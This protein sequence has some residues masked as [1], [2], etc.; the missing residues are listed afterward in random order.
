[1]VQNG[2]HNVNAAPCGVGQL[3]DGC[4]DGVDVLRNFGDFMLLCKV[5]DHLQVMI[6]VVV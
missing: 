6:H 4:A 1:M 2:V 5:I 3:V